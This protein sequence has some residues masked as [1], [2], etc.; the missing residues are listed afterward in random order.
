[1]K[2]LI[3]LI[4]SIP[5]FSFAAG[6]LNGGGDKGIVCRD[7]DQEII[8][9][10]TLDLYEARVQYGLEVKVKSD[11]YIKMAIE[12]LTILGAGRGPEFTKQIITLALRIDRIK[13]LVPEGTSLQILDDSYEIVTPKNCQIEQL[14]N[15][16]NNGLILVSGEMWHA[17]DEVNKAA[18]IVH[19]TIYYEFRT[20]TG[21]TNSIH[22]RKAVAYGF[23]G[24]VLEGVKDGVPDISAILC[25]TYSSKN[26]Y[27]PTKYWIYPDSDPTFEIIQ[28]D[29]LDGILMLTKTYMK[30]A[31]RYVSGKLQFFCLG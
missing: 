1:M 23:S 30:A 24:V 28:F 17:L 27:G 25:D 7:S 3:A 5:S 12:V 11:S 21:A 22:A 16:V 14:A 15:Y 9:V 29:I 26:S 8:S 19:E 4:L 31:K 20:E 2:F 18:L 10:E 13:K 6:V